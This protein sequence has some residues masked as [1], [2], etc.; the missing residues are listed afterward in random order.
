MIIQ[1]VVNNWYGLIFVTLR[2]FFVALWYSLHQAPGR[3]AKVLVTIL[4]WRK[5]VATID[6]KFWS[7]FA[8]FR[9]LKLDVF[10]FFFFKNFQFFAAKFVGSILASH[11]R[12]FAPSQN[13]APTLFGCQ[14]IAINYFQFLRFE[15]LRMVKKRNDSQRAKKG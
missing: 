2:W 7:M 14:I 13:I 3:Q 5:L 4:V 6:Q 8:E 15:G 1:C 10:Y 12:Q 11:G 9:R